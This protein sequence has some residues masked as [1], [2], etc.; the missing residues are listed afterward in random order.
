MFRLR[1]VRG[2]QHRNIRNREKFGSRSQV[3]INDRGELGG[4]LITRV[5]SICP[6]AKLTLTKICMV[7]RSTKIFA[8][9]KNHKAGFRDCVWII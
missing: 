9:K 5:G 8:H 7:R 4:I 3:D 6:K 2:L 1:G